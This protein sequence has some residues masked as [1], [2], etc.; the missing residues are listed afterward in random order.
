MLSETRDEDA[1]RRDVNQDPSCSLPRLT[2]FVQKHSSHKKTRPKTQSD[3]LKMLET[4]P[5]HKDNLSPFNPLPAI[6]HRN[7]TWED[8]LASNEFKKQIK[9]GK[10]IHFKN[11]NNHFV[12]SV[13]NFEGNL[14]SGNHTNRQFLQSSGRKLNDLKIKTQH[15]KFSDINNNKDETVSH[16]LQEIKSNR[17][18]DYQRQYLSRHFESTNDDNLTDLNQS[19]SQKTFS[20]KEETLLKVA[21]QE[22]DHT[23][24]VIDRPFKIETLAER[25]LSEEDHPPITESLPQ[26]D[27]CNPTMALG[28]NIFQKRVKLLERRKRESFV[29]IDDVALKDLQEHMELQ[30]KAKNE[31]KEFDYSSS[32]DGESGS[33][34]P[35]ISHLVGILNH[36]QI[37]K[38]RKGRVKMTNNWF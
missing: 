17:S 24:K 25:N 34:L 10:E 33:A 20:V 9:S 5:S 11:I 38:S 2:G 37:S 27:L 3:I 26:L 36:T 15:I 22:S 16:I 14:Q 7:Q 12:V 8:R 30:S 6:G 4:E 28:S 19:V 32:S 18:K 29:K 23:E 13:N 31:S 21:H 35:K 1:S